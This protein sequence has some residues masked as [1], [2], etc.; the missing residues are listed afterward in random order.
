MLE[1]EDQENQESENYSKDDTTY[2]QLD[3]GDQLLCILQRCP[4]H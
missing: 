3:D 1:E 4:R 2:V